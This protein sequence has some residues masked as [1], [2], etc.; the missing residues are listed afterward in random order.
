MRS[1]LAI[2]TLLALLSGV[3]PAHAVHAWFSDEPLCR[4]ACAGTDHCC[5]KKRQ[6]GRD[7]SRRDDAPA[8]AETQPEPCC[9]EDCA[10]TTG[11]QRLPSSGAAFRAEHEQPLPAASLKVPAG[12]FAPRRGQITPS[13]PRAPPA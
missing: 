12:V 3:V 13:R 7:P 8:T 11:L 5:C 1:L 9:G 4:E 6:I 2:G 10:V